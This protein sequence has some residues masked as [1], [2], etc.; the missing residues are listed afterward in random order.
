M[1]I[2]GFFLPVDDNDGGDIS[3]FFQFHWE[4]NLKSSEIYASW[5]VIALATRLPQSA[6]TPSRY[7]PND[8]V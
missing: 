7:L 3:L 5:E 6:L 2:V 8:I 1:L 4:V